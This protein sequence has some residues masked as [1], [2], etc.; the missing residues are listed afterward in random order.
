[1]NE[2]IPFFFFNFKD[3]TLTSKYYHCLLS[4]FA[5]YS[6]DDLCALDNLETL[7]QPLLS[8]TGELGEMCQRSETAWISPDLEKEGKGFV[9]GFCWR[10]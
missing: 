8:D 6:L 4:Y 2:A 7:L 3:K 5:T 1:M 9:N 10:Q